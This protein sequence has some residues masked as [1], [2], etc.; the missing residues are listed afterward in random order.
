MTVVAMRKALAELV[1]TFVLVLVSAGAGVVVADAGGAPL[2]VG[3]A[4]G[5]GLAAAI[6]VLAPVSGAHFNP[7]VTLALLALR[8][9]RPQLAVGYVVA[10]VLGALAAALL[11]RATFPASATLEA[12]A[13]TVGGG[14]GLAGAF[15]LEVVI[16]AV[17]V[18]VIL[19]LAVWTTTAPAV[20]GSVIGAWVAVAITVFGP[21]TGASM[22][23]A[24][25]LGPAIAFD[26]YDDLWVYVVAPLAGGLLAVAI[27]PVLLG[28]RPRE[29]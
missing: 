27:A 6:A 29:G 22:N 14:V 1:G 16:T 3:L 12:G 2:E 19:G 11:L 23:P 9:I 13:T 17:L 18:L 20:S 5:L 25:T 8:R 15:V 4:T 21:I 7:A 10:Q 24:R 28:R 26:V